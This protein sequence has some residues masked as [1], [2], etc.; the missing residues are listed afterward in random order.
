MNKHK[1]LFIQNNFCQCTQDITH[2][3]R[4]VKFFYCCTLTCPSSSPFST[5]YM[6]AYMKEL[7]S[8][9]KC[10]RRLVHLYAAARMPFSI[11]ANT[12][13]LLYTSA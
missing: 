12:V 11:P 10:C 3:I 8:E 4:H 13:E 5:P 6:K 1:P 7:F 9:T 2:G